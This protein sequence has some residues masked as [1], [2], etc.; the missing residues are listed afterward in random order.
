MKVEEPGEN[1][2]HN[3]AFFAEETLLRSE[4]E[5]ARDCHPLTARHWIVSLPCVSLPTP[6]Y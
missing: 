3:N 5:A 2:V 4:L 6:N 1:N